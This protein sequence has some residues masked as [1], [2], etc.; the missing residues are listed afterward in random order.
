LIE[1]PLIIQ[2]LSEFLKAAFFEV[3]DWEK[4]YLSVSLN[5]LEVQLISEPLDERTVDK[6]SDAEVISVFIYSNLNRELIKKIGKARLITTRSTGY[7]HID[8]VACKERGIIVCNVPVYGDTPVAEHTFA[9]ILSL[10]RGIHDSYEL[11]RRGEFT[12]ENV[13]GFDLN[14]KILGVLGTGKIGRK[15]IEIARGFK[16]NVLAYDRFPSKKLSEILNFQYADWREVLQKSDILSLHLPLTDETFH[17]LNKE[18][19]GMMKSGAVL[20]NTARGALIDSQ[21]LTEALMNGHLR[22]AGLDVL[23]EEA[24]IREEAQLLLDNVPRERLARMLRTHILLRLKNVIITPHCAFNSQESL[25]RLVEV[26][27]NNIKA[28]R[29]GKPQNTIHN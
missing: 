2:G 3:Q 5:G 13:S 24:L 1:E 9:L 29:E 16:M 27:I 19:I 23:E 15:V 20:I 11:T 12:C 8:I 17:F 28:F 6:A 26:T 14:G 7:D 10:S 18:T 25:Q 4:P 22:G 21:A